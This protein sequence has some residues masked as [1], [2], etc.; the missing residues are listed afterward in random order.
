MHQLWLQ[1]KI[2]D[3]EIQE[4]YRG[5]REHINKGTTFYIIQNLDN[6]FH[7]LFKGVEIL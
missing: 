1:G 2:T 3:I 6:Y 4:S 5:F 7:S